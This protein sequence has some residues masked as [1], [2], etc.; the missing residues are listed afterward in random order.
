VTTGEWTFAFVDLAGF[1]ALTEVHGDET[2]ADQAIH[3]YELA[4]DSLT[5]SSHLVKQIGDAVLI[6]ADTSEDVV[7]TVLQLLTAIDHESNFPLVRAGLHAGTAVRSTTQGSV[8]YLGTGVNIA[9]R[10]AAQASGRQLLLT[11]TVARAIDKDRWPLRGLGHTHFRNVQ[12]PIEMFELI[13]RDQQDG[14]VDPVCRMRV[15][16][17]GVVGSLRHDGIDYVFCSLH[18][19]AMFAADP[20]RFARVR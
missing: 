20:D 4:H 6:A 11:E 17:G 8:D 15:T 2:A 13:L 1:T 7:R 18:C 12:Q 16:P 19:V 5:G 3:F 14:E 10:A 9:A